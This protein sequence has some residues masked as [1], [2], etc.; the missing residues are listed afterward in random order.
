MGYR[1]LEL[2]MPLKE[3][4]ERTKMLCIMLKG[5]VLSLFLKRSLFLN[6]IFSKRC[7]GEDIETTDQELLEL[8][9]REVGLD[10]I[11]RRAIRVQKYYMRRCL[12]M[13]PNTTVQQFVERLNELHQYLLFFP[14]E[15]PTPLTQHEIIEILDQAKP[16]NWHKVMVSA[17]IDIIE[18]DYESAILYF[19]CLENLDKI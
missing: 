6:I 17:N 13:G 9:I 11:S 4:S 18:M 16:P 3:L 14:E 10:H 1:D 12:F 19:I 2:L 8:V 15:C 7:G 5:C